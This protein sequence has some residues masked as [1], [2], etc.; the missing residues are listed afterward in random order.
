MEENRNVT[1]GQALDT[2][3]SVETP[4]TTKEEPSKTN[5]SRKADF[6]NGYKKFES[7]WERGEEKV[8]AF[9]RKIQY[10][11]LFVFITIIAFVLRTL[12]FKMRTGDY[13]SFLI[14]W[15]DHIKANGGFLALGEKIGD[16]TPAYF[17]IL[18]FLTYLPFDSLYSIKVVSCLFDI[19]LAT[20]VTLCAWQFSKN[21]KVAVSVYA[22][23]SLLPTVFFN[24]GAWAQCDGIYVSFAVLCLYFL[25]RKKNFTAMIMYG[26]SFSFKLQAIF[27]APL[28]GVLWFKRKIPRTS[29]LVALGVFFLSC[30]PAWILGRDL[31]EVLTTYFAQAG[32]YSSRLTLNAPTLMALLGTVSKSWV[33]YISSTFVV[34]TLAVTVFVMYL[35]GHTDLGKDVLVDF[36]LLFALGVP[37]LLPHMHERYFYMADVLAII[38]GVLHRKR[39]YTVLLTQFC[40][41]YVIVEYLFTLNYLSLAEVA[42]VEGVNIILLCKDLWKDY[43][44][45]N[46]APALLAGKR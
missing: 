13:N 24:S 22:I 4:V 10:P 29:P 18:A 20:S 15:F 2:A 11:L 23:V 28:L 37:Y 46:R 7:A 1:E 6:I 38:Y 3:T 30:V 43:S 31:W 35:C 17:Y 25:M 5:P 21:K 40:S 14:K 39:W 12:M 16:Y 45:R 34:L 27:I 32:Q 9:F 42:I 41:F 19:L 44:T 33:E 8:G 26:I 36:G